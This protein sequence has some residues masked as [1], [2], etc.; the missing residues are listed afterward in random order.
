[1]VERGTP[2][3]IV[4]DASKFLDWAC[5]K[6]MEDFNDDTSEPS[7]AED[8]NEVHEHRHEKALHDYETNGHLAGLDG[9]NDPPMAR[10]SIESAQNGGSGIYG[11]VT[12]AVGAAGEIV[13]AHTPAMIANHFP[14]HAASLTDAGGEST[15][16]IRRSSIDSASSVGSFASA[17]EVNEEECLPTAANDNDSNSQRSQATSQQDKELQKLEDR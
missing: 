11:M 14:V 13:A 3:G 12:S 10:E 15:S 5:G 1:M 4:S 7:E 17:L 8:P 16:S 2:S 9:Q 6:D